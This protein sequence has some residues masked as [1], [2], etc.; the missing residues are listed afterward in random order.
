MPKVT[1]SDSVE[2]ANRDQ[3]SKQSNK[4][5]LYL[6]IQR[7]DL[8]WPRG[9][10]VGERWEWEFGICRCKLLCIEGINNKVLLYSTVNYIQY[11]YYTIMQKNRKNIYV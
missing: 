6:Q 7:T 9:R 8:W 1:D 10:G 4:Q 2:E 3:Q 5:K 11:P